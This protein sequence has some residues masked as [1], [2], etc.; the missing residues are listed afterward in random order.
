MTNIYAIIGY[1][2]SLTNRAESK[3]IYR[4]LKQNEI[5]QYH[6]SGNYPDA[7]WLG[8]KLQRLEGGRE[9]QDFNTQVQI[10]PTNE[11]MDETLANIRAFLESDEV[12]EEEKQYIRDRGYPKVFILFGDN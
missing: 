7:V 8:V 5:V 9:Y 12:P 2:Y 10:S 1:G 6:Y 11:Q 4:E 3:R